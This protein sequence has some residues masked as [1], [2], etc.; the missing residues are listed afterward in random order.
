[1]FYFTIISAVDYVFL[2]QKRLHTV[3][4]PSSPASASAGRGI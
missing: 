3:S 1:V 4:H 2:V